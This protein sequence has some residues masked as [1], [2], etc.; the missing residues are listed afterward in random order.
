[1]PRTAKPYPAAVVWYRLS[2][3]EEAGPYPAA[4]AA[5]GYS[6]VG[7]GG[8]AVGKA[9]EGAATAVLGCPRP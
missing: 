4:A 1:M 3:G 5:E 6:R 9:L 2:G 8:G 7:E